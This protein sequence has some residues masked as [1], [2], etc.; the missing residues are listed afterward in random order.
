MGT[1]L[2]DAQWELIRPLLPAAK[3]TGRPRADN[4][5]NLNGILYVLR[6]GLRGLT[7]L[8]RQLP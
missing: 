2:S 7:H 1:D 5:R 8:L 4:R 6:P 3:P